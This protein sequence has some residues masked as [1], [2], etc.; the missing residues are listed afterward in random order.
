[1]KRSI[2]SLNGYTLA[3]VDGE[4]GTVEEFYFDDE[5]LT[6][7]YLIVKTGYWWFGRKILIPTRA[8]GNPDCESLK[9][10]INLTKEEVRNSPDIDTDKPVS[11]KHETELYN[12]FQWQNYWSP[13]AL[14]VGVW[15]LTGTVPLVTE[16][17]PES[18]NAATQEP[19]NDVHL[20][21][22]REL[23]G[24]SVHGTDSKVGK[25]EDFIIDDNTWK[26]TFFV[27]DAGSWMH[28][29][30]VLLSPG[31]VRE[32]SWSNSAIYVSM[33]AVAIENGPEYD[34]SKT[35]N[36]LYQNRFYD[37]YGRP[38]PINS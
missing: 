3:A 38:H 15:G 23:T 22:T 24:Y 12:H 7:R 16:R 21:S 28:G 35:V 9:F 8:V 36:V 14:S 30:K 10:P 2:K 18:E 13:G 17:I 1:M 4:I 33:P 5:T 20:R 19:D 37:Y 25:V 32:I 29:K 26:L 11:R 6:V 34:P 27:V 31:C